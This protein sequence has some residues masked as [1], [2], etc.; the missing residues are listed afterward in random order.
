MIGFLGEDA[1]RKA[2]ANAQALDSRTVFQPV[3]PKL[4][5]LIKPTATAAP[6]RGA[7]GVNQTVPKKAA[8]SS[9]TPVLV[10]GGIAVAGLVA[11][12]IIKK[13]KKKA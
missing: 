3:G 1:L 7:T 9:M 11:F 10:V 5:T 4:A 2:L 6:V 12:V 8:S 13:R